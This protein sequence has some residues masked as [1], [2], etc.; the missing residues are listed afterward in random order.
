MNFRRLTVNGVKHDAGRA[1]PCADSWLATD[2]SG[3]VAEAVP[4]F[5][6]IDPRFDAHGERL[7]ALSRDIAL[8]T[9]RAALAAR[10]IPQS[11]AQPLYTRWLDSAGWA[12]P[13]RDLFV[14]IARRDGDGWT[15]RILTL[16][17]TLKVRDRTVPVCDLANLLPPLDPQMLTV[18]QRRSLDAGSC[19]LL[20]ASAAGRYLI[21]GSINPISADL[22]ADLLGEMPNADGYFPMCLAQR[23]SYGAW[24][25]RLTPVQQVHPAPTVRAPLATGE[26]RWM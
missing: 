4:D 17:E 25:S 12:G 8:A 24:R 21:I 3:R 18:P 1:E 26:A 2:S 7:A 5:G 19:V 10:R 23:I 22:T 20:Q 13:D 15:D 9:V 11:E 14:V 6:T 16:S